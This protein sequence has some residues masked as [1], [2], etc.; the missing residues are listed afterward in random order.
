MNNFLNKKNYFAMP[1]FYKRN[2]EYVDFDPIEK[3]D[4]FFLKMTLIEGNLSTGKSTFMHNQVD[5]TSKLRPALYIQ[6]K[7]QDN[8]N[9]MNSFFN[10]QICSRVLFSKEGNLKYS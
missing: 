10:S 9:S 7:T 4:I 8:V 2:F 6:F 3:E 1:V 5:Q